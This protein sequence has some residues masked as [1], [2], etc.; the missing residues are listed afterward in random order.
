MEELCG[1]K[2]DILCKNTKRMWESYVVVFF[3]FL[4]FYLR[5]ESQK[6]FDLFKILCISDC[7]CDLIILRYIC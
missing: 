4:E 3:F 6:S 1:N 5:Q 2:E 7:S